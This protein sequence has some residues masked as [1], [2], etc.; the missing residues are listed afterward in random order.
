MF[1]N[2]SNVTVHVNALALLVAD[3]NSFQLPGC[4]G[5]HLNIFQTVNNPEINM[6]DKLIAT[7]IL[8]R[9]SKQAS[10]IEY[11]KKCL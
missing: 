9:K 11:P 5:N 3:L 8:T 4:P 10:T 7:R 6:I 1:L 2:L